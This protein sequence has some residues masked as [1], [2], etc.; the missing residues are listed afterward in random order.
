LKKTTS[1]WFACLAVLL[2]GCG[3]K[4]ADATPEQAPPP[5]VGVGVAAAADS[6]TRFQLW[7]MTH[8]PDKASIPAVTPGKIAT[9]L[10]KGLD[11]PGLVARVGMPEWQA[12]ILWSWDD[13][14]PVEP[15]AQRE[16]ERLDNK[17]MTNSYSACIWPGAGIVGRVGRSC[18]MQS[19][20]CFAA[21]NKLDDRTMDLTA[22]VE[23]A[24]DAAMRSIKSA[25]SNAIGE[26]IRTTK[27]CK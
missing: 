11:V 20:A 7:L 9:D 6:A 16:L 1:L 3:Q 2:S 10:L 14:G 13:M 4:K 15:E 23:M 8:Q 17:Y 21:R 27:F 25:G 18:V 26:F 19:Y 12:L 24:D 5:A 22:A